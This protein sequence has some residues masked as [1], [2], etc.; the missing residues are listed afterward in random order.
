MLDRLKV[1]AIRNSE[2]FAPWRLLMY[3]VTMSICALKS[4]HYTKLSVAG[5][6]HYWKFHCTFI[7][8]TK[9]RRKI[10]KNIKHKILLECNL[11]LFGMCF[12][13][14][15]QESVYFYVQRIHRVAQELQ[16][17]YLVLL[18]C[19]TVGFSK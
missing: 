14:N 6:D 16:V 13:E 9:F 19:A 11:K 2:V 10:T 17:T 12:L 8:R 1:V 3:K 4:L 7:V 5:R 18:P 15:K